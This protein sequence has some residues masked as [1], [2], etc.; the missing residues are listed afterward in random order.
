MHQGSRRAMS[1]VG[2]NM[3]NVGCSVSGARFCPAAVP[4]EA[5][6]KRERLP[7]AP[8]PC[9]KAPGKGR[10]R[11][12]ARP[13]PRILERFISE[14]DK[15]LYCLEQFQFE[16]LRL[17]NHTVCRFA[18]KA[19]FSALFRPGGAVPP[20]RVSSFSKLKRSK[21]FFWGEG[22]PLG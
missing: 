16:M 10:T 5:A 6:G 8:A 4:A 9:R 3:A 19:R 15:T 21:S 20:P 14:K 2:K 12:G 11:G 1:E 18:E 17:A 7:R 22:N 13:S